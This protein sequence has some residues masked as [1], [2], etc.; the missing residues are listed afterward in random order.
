M[1]ILITIPDG[2]YSYVQEQ[3]SDVDLTRDTLLNH[4]MRG[5]LDGVVIEDRPCQDC[6]YLLD[7]SDHS[8]EMCNTCRRI[9]CNFEPKE[10]KNAD[11]N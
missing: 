7:Y 11:S 4:I 1:Q 9:R 8:V 3:W 5:I 10:N 6:K 2:I